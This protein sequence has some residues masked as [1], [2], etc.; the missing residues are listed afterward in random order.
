VPVDATCSNFDPNAFQ[1]CVQESNSVETCKQFVAATNAPGGSPVCVPSGSALAFHAFGSRSQ[2]D[3]EGTAHIAIGDSEPT[4]QP[5]TVGRVEF[6]GRPCPA[7]G[8][9]VQPYFELRMDPITFSVKW[10]SDPTFVDLSASGR[11]LDAAVFGG[12][13]ISYAALGVAGTGNGRRL[14]DL[15][16]HNANLALDAKNSEPLDFGIDW[17][18]RQCDMVGSVAGAVGD[19]GLCAGDGATACRV[20]AECETVGGPCD[21]PADTEAMNVD[22]ALAGT[23]VNQPPTAVAGADQNVECTSAAGASFTLDGRASSDPD[24]NLALASWREGSRVGT[25][26]VNGLG[27]E[28]ALGVGESKQYVLR[29]IDGFAQTD[30]DTT[31]VSVLDTT[32]PAISCNA[33]ATM[34]P[35]NRPVT[36]TA[37]A[38]DVCTAGSIAPAVVG[39]ECFKL[40]A[41]GEKLDKTKTCKVAL[42]GAKITISPPQGV[43]QHVAWTVR[44]VDATGNVGEVTCEIEVVKQN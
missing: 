3:V 14:I 41:K 27:A 16:T 26:I 17:A 35:P 20:D 28:V 37:T 34:P 42:Q 8:C 12:G 11:G 9:R 40:N 36:F 33:P 44:A 18:A 43:G 4:R 6:L 2:C 29:V 24:G 19:D 30:E 1:R 15:V 39:F 13:E 25:L 21:L 10:A 38:T 32:P 5:A 7:G 31:T 23:I 22:V